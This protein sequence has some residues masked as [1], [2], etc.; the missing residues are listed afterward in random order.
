MLASDDVS[1]QASAFGTHVAKVLS[2]LVLVKIVLV[3][4]DFRA[5]LIVAFEHRTLCL[6]DK[7]L[8]LT[9]ILL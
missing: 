9:L 7:L 4:I 5:V 1:I 8:D 6:I 3:V 2:D